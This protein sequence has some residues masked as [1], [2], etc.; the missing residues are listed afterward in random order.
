LQYRKEKEPLKPIISDGPGHRMFFDFT[1]LGTC[2][3]TGARYGLVLI[4]HFTSRVWGETFATKIQEDVARWLFVWLMSM[5]LLPGILHC[6]NGGEFINGCVA[7][8]FHM[9]SLA[10]AH[11]RPYHPQSQVLHQGPF[12][13][14]T[15]CDS[16]L[17][18]A[19]TALCLYLFVV[20]R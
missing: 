19:K 17:V 13:S 8:V 2:S 18:C 16:I 10:E 15:P 6:D 12:Y 5:D 4:D 3:V 20:G 7:A 9:F 11:G 1:E 14:V